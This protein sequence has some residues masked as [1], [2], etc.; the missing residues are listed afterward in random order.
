MWNFTSAPLFSSSF[1]R[2]RSRSEQTIPLLRREVA[3][4]GERVAATDRVVVP[5]ADV[6]RG[7][8]AGHH[9]VA[10]LAVDLDPADAPG[11]VLRQQD[12][13]V[14]GVGRAGDG[15]AGHDGAVALAR[16]TPAPAAGETRRR[17][18]AA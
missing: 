8:L 18:A 9:G 2:G 13:L 10:G 11:E 17:S 7:A 5:V 3:G 1:S 15:D 6:E 14:A 4:H 12:D 16:R